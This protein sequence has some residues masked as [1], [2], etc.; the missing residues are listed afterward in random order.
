[1]GFAPAGFELTA[2]VST[3]ATHEIHFTQDFTTWRLLAAANGT[4]STV[5]LADD[6][7]TNRSR[8]FY[9]TVSQAGPRREPFHA[10]AWDQ[11]PADCTNLTRFI[12][13]T[14]TSV[15]E[16]IAT[17]SLARAE[18]RSALFSWDL[19]R[20]LLSHSNDMCLTP[21]GQ[22]T[23]NQS[24]W[25]SNGIATI[26]AKFDTFFRRFRD[27]GGRVDWLIIDYEENY[28]NWSI[29][30]MSASNRWLAIQNDP[31][32]PLLAQRLG[33]SNLLAVAN[34]SGGREYLK[35]NAVMAGVG[36]DALNQAV[37][38]PARQYF[39][40][41]RCSNYGSVIMDETNAVPD[42]NGHWG[43]SEGNPTGTH[44]APSCYAWIGQLANKVL[45]GMNPFGQS[46]FAGVLLEVNAARAERRSSPVPMQPW[47]AWR[48]YAGDGP[49]LPLAVVGN[50]PYYREL[51]LHLALL[52][53]DGFLFWNP[54]PWATNQNPQDYSLP[55][56]ERYLDGILGELADKL[57]PSGG[58]PLT[59]EPVPW[60]AKVIASAQQ[61]DGR[62]V[63]RFTFAEGVDAWPA[64][65]DGQPI[66]LRP[67][68]NEVGAWLVHPAGS[69]LVLESPTNIV[70][71][72][73]LWKYSDQ[74]LNLGSAWVDP[75]F[76]D[77]A[78]PSGPSPLGYGDAN[79]VLPA[80]TNS[81]GP[82]SNDKFITTYYRHAFV[83]TNT[84]AVP[85][86]SI[87]VDDGAIVYLNG[88]KVL[89]V[90][91]TNTVVDWRTLANSSIGGSMETNWYS[92]NLPPA[93][94]V[95]GTN[96]LAAEVHQAA[97]DSSDLFFN[98][99]LTG[100]MLW[101]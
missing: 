18:G 6:G 20:G 30:D 8:T 33:F 55:D 77:R 74:G 21:A 72:G 12:W 40:A 89:G 11:P 54:H 38:E 99:K 7:A 67:A 32:F 5:R 48:R 87:Q 64:T 52:G 1:V 58:P 10:F 45:D 97:T 9:R 29:G 39:P 94:F 56:D 57:S 36:N 70:S 27:A 26:R 47:V 78:W 22:P 34:W 79:G 49:G 82:N 75:A 13:F 4:S 37:F 2:L 86:L 14:K 16:Q 42:L 90:N 101:P 100:L 60:D 88:T 44:Q 43:W 46:P 65:L 28:S 66:T 53:N 81:F 84:V 69:R 76:D 92:T 15:P 83:L 61:V 41:L 19:H 68:T 51:V 35:W 71:S 3:G 23:T 96:V 80:T 25:P 95:R 59:L 63:W 62:V 91:L 17:Q 24:V 73:A 50:T 31:R 85:N 98:L 93:L